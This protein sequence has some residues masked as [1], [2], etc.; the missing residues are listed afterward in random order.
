MLECVFHENLQGHGRERKLRV[1]IRVNAEFIVEGISAVV[2][3]YAYV[4]VCK[5]QFFRKW[6]KNLRCN[7]LLPSY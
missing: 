4:V 7:Y 2:A 3:D 1:D 5:F 6:Y